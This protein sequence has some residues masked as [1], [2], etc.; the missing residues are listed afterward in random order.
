MALQEPLRVLEGWLPWCPLENCWRGS[1]IPS[2]RGLY[3]IRR[4]GE[5]GLDYIGQT[6]LTLR[7]RL[8][9]LVGVYQLEMPYR[10][11]HTAAPALWA[12][13]QALGCTFEASVIPV[14]GDTRYRKGLEA[15]AIALYRQERGQSPTV[16]FGRIRRGYRLSSGNN[17]R[18]VAA[19]K[20]LRGGLTTVAQDNWLEGASPVGALDGDPQD[21]RWGGHRWSDRAPLREA[22]AQLTAK[23]PGLYRIRNSDRPGLVYV[24]EGSIPERLA[25]HLAKSNKA[26]HRQRTLS[27]TGLE[28]AWTV[29]PAWPRHQRLELETDLIGAHVLST[30]HAPTAQFLG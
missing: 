14:P 23:T 27:A 20:R 25:A 21:A 12:L 24:G 8:G 3:R 10:D 13:R 5:V 17:A 1:A 28:C 7:R 6:G 22:Q 4:V 19:G 9:M 29:N 18:L 15:L 16:N 2:E 26:G 30:G 11:P